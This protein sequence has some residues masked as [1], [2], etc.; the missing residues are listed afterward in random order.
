MADQPKARKA[1]GKPAAK[2]GAASSAASVPAAVS[3]A[4][5]ASPAEI[6]LDDADSETDSPV[7]AG[8]GAAAVAEKPKAQTVQ[9]KASLSAEYIA[10]HLGMFT[11]GEPGDK[12]I[13]SR[14]YGTAANSTV[15][16]PVAKQ[17]PSGT[18][19]KD[20]MADVFFRTGTSGVWVCTIPGC[21]RPTV[22]VHVTESGVEDARGAE[23]HLETTHAHLL[24][25]DHPKFPRSA[26][27]ASQHT[28]LEIAW[29]YQ[30]LT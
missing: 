20:G 24:P 26:M 15:P 8:T 7:G 9:Y 11:T 23:S 17:L 27:A 29:N 18:T 10:A 28:E 4:S 13:A 5:S 3:V 25:P 12:A 14:P 2:S 16:A 30:L 21:P 1:T 6:Q 19:K 22:R